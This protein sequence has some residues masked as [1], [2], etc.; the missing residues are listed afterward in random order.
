MLVGSHNVTKLYA[1][2]V[3]TCREDMEHAVD[4]LLCVLVT[5]QKGL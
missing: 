5:A 2:V 3:T 4:V 1:C